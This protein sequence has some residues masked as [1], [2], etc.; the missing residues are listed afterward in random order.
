MQTSKPKYLYISDE[1]YPLNGNLIKYYLTSNNLNK[2]QLAKNLGILPT[3]L[4]QYFKQDSLQFGVLWRL[5]KALNHNFPAQMSEFL[6]IPFETQN[7][8][9]LKATLA[10]KYSLIREMEI[11][12]KILRELRK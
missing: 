12:L 1:H 9:K 7:E 11:E 10:E 2:T 3:T 4:Y 5:S 8:K 6:Q